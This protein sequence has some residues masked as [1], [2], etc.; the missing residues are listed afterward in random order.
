MLKAVIFDLFETLITEWG[1]EKYT[2]KKISEDLGLDLELFNRYWEENEQGRYQ[3]KVSFEDSIRY[4][5]MRCGVTLLPETLARVTGK[6]MA[7]K[8]ACFDFIDPDIIV[9]VKELKARGL[10]LGMLSNCSS[11]E[12]TAIRQSQ[13]CAFFDALVLSYEA[14]LSKPDP[15][16]YSRVL[17]ELHVTA[18]ECLFVGDGGSNELEGARRAGMAA[19]QAKWY[20]D[21]HPMKRESMEGFNAAQR[22]LEL[23]RYFTAQP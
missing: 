7:T 23:L 22:P 17:A 1:H 14:G 2:K 19:V 15:L 9:L 16:I 8:A 20:T 10:R 5:C 6:R 13:L 11:E 18:A 3:G 12:V 4:V 21:R